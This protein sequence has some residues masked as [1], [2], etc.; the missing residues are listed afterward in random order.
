MFLALPDFCR[1]L[2]AFFF[3]LAGAGE[4]TGLNGFVVEYVSIYFGLVSL[5]AS[6]RLH[7]FKRFFH[8]CLSKLPLVKISAACTF[9]LI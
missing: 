6:T 3:G 5:V 4:N 1:G 2:F 8:C 9:V 7:R